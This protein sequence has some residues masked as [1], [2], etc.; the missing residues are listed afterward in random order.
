[1]KLNIKKNKLADILNLQ[2]GVF[3]PLKEYVSKIDFVSIVNKHRLKNG[4]FFP[5]PIYFN[6]DLLEYEKIKAKK[7]IN[8]FFKSKKVC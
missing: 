5:F 2:F 1:M 8:L 7:S 4:K 6:I 3:N